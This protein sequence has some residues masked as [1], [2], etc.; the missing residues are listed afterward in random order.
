[1]LTIKSHALK[2]L[3]LSLMCLGGSA[4]IY[5]KV[6]LDHLKV[7]YQKEPLGIDVD[8]PSF[9][10]Q[11][12]V[13]ENETGQL[14]EA[15]QIIVVDEES[16]KVWDSGKISSD[17]S[18]GIIYKGA[19][20]KPSTR[21]TWTVMVWGQSEATTSSTSWFETG[22]MNPDPALSAWEGATWIGGTD[23]DLVFNAHYLSVFKMEYALALDEASRSTKASFIFGANDRRLMDKNRNLFG[24]QN[25]INQSYIAFEL[26]I[27]PLNANPKGR[28]KLNVYRVG[29]A[30]HDQA[31]EPFES[32]EI[33]TALINN[34]NKYHQHDFYIECN[35]GIFNIYLNGREDANNLTFS[36]EPITIPFLSPAGLNLNP[37]GGG[38]G[39]DYIS[40][41]MV[42]D[43]G[44]RV[45]K[46][47]KAHLS[48]LRVRHLRLPSNTIFSDFEEGLSI[49]GK[50]EGTF[51]VSDPS[52]NAIPM[53]RTSFETADKVVKKARLY[54]TARGIYEMYI[55]GQRIGNDYFNPGLTQ[56]NRT[57]MYQTYDVTTSIQQGASNAIGAWLGEGWWSGN[58]TYRGEHWN[59]F[60]DR[61]S[62]LAKLV[63]T[64]V[65]GSKKVITTN[66]KDWKYFNEGPIRIGSF[67]QGE[68]YDATKETAIAG[69]TR[70]A[71]DDKNWKKAVE[72]PLQ[73]TSFVGSYMDFLGREIQVE[74]D[75]Q[76]IIGQIG[77]NVQI[78][79]IRTAESVREV[80][81]GVFVYDM[82][83]NMVGFPNI[84]IEDGM[85]GDTIT[86]R[87]AEVTYPDL[88]EY[89]GNVGMVM[90]ENIRSAL[91]QDLYIRKGGAEVIQPRFTFHGYRFV[92]I[93]GISE[94]LPLEDVKGLVLSSVHQL[95]SHYETSNELVNK[96]WQNISWS[97]RGNFLSI[98]TDTPARNERMGWSG[99]INV[100][101][102]ASTYLGDVNQFF[103]RHLQAMRDMQ[104][105]NG[106]F[107]D[108]APVGCGFGG[109]LWGS[110]G[111][112]VAWEAY[113]QYGDL[114]LLR[115]HYQAMKDYVIF[116]DTKIDSSTN[117]FVEG[118]LGDW[119]SPEN[120]KNDDTQLWTAYHLY[121]L[122]IMIKVGTLLGKKE[123]VAF[124]RKRYED[125]KRFF[126]ETY[127]DKKSHKTI[128]TALKMG[129]LQPTVFD[130]SIKGKEIDTQA[131]YA[132][133]L[134]FG[135]FDDEYKAAI[136]KHLAATVT[137]KN[138]DD[139]GKLLPEY[140][141]MTGFIGTAVLGQALSENGRSDLAY[142]LLQ[143]ES[144]PSWLYPVVNGATTI[145][146]R[147]N[148]YTI[149]NGF[150]GNNR[151]NSFNHYAFGAVASW[152]YNYSLGIQRDPEQAAFK[153]FLLKPTPDPTGQM[154]WAKGYYDSMYGRISSEWYLKKDSLIYKTSVPPNTTAMLYLPASSLNE[155]YVNGKRIEQI[156][157][158]SYLSQ[159]NDCLV[160]KLE[161]GNFRFVVLAYNSYYPR[162]TTYTIASAYK[163]VKERYPDVVPV[164]NNLP[165][166]VQLS[167]NVVYAELEGGR[168]LHLDLF[169]PKTRS[170]KLP[171]VLIIHGGGWRA[172]SKEN[173][174]PM[175]EQLAAKGYVTATVEYRLSGEAPY[176]AAV[177][178]LKAA[179][180]WLRANAETYGIDTSKIAAYGCSAGAHLATLLGTTNESTLFDKHRGNAAY[181]TKVQAILNI[182]G[183][184]SFIHPEAKPEWTGPSATAWL[185]KYEENYERWKEAS[186]LEYAGKHTPPT[187]FVNSSYPRFHAGRDDLIAILN[188]FGTY[189]E[190]HTFGGS[191]HGFWLYEPW[192]EP[193]LN[194]VN[195]FLKKVFSEP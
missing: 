21:Y 44:Y 166:S 30:P 154:T 143:Q 175:A 75:D 60:G 178:D 171:A 18:V 142:K 115:Q 127:V 110:A 174:V 69:W 77:E 123:D 55:N 132:I 85:K 42:G 191:P 62:L 11:M 163:Q 165:E 45:G 91:T 24:M 179:V 160:F 65:D 104:E 189:N 182:D 169:Q 32:I 193:T 102:R 161:S 19:T 167:P 59:Y 56:Y 168:K 61:Q 187:L 180:R 31:E 8:K 153:S 96:L 150:G 136:I 97:M 128:R 20:L 156:K 53:L 54:V 13:D 43:I 139:D 47:Q 183:I 112:V 121:D 86:L 83:Q 99:D 113:Q 37:Y 93:T 9:S 119:L 5:A 135:L 118:P 109:V 40:F 125:R 146:E 116:L 147:L 92:E 177:H 81:P 68:I 98:P 145:W 164:R 155:V 108:V 7:E 162:D 58:I 74:Y 25:K 117:L 103:K 35:F 63:I 134:A 170:K 141:L 82:G 1:M 29:Y 101:S 176:P 100:F 79:A 41:P 181:S 151:M 120:G 133:P 48:K 95:S 80:R 131:S 130:P 46:N 64:Y 14:Q 22:L 158:V 2:R 27:S 184:A 34:N 3:I 111:I 12:K 114:K 159:Q 16:L 192:F 17:I 172:G 105:E 6:G 90:M 94:A 188:Q 137:R 190:I 84:R 67:F 194:L 39:G 23:D 70:A 186:P 106:R 129:F 144:Y 52:R 89:E 49:E 36:D 72:V 138:T 33:S 38:Q 50:E 28:A 76:K 15:Y 195:S 10:W 87:Y 148:S 73:G 107:T 51:V 173:M 124:Y 71:F 185:D 157:A 152:M 4:L 126:N 78:V 140:S 149:E 57:H 122:E 66:D 26:D 88:P